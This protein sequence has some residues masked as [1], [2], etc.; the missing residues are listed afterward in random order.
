MP[1]DSQTKIPKRCKKHTKRGHQRNDKIWIIKQSETHS[2]NCKVAIEL[3]IIV[4]I[5]KISGG[6]LSENTFSYYLTPHPMI[7]FA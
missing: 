7:R 6:Y 3:K 4:C 2:Y 1:P 5:I